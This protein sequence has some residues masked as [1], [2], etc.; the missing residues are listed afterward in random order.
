VLGCVYAPR[1]NEMYFAEKG[2]GAFLNDEPIHV[3]DHDNLADCTATTGFACIR[4]RREKN[5]LPCFGEFAARTRGVRRYGSAAMDLCFV[6]AGRVDF[7]WE[8]PLNLYDVAA[9]VV[10]V[11]EAGGTVTDF[12]GGNHI[13]Q[14]GII[15]SNGIVHEQVREIILSHDYR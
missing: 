4:A 11:R 6:A 1:L 15:A 14:N 7:S 2:K 8:F 10:I 13:P 5:N 9:G 3:T 12:D